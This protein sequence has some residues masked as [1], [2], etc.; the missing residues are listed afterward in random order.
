MKFRSR[1]KDIIRLASTIGHVCLI[2]EEWSEVPEHME[3]EAYSKG[4]ISEEMYET[5][6][7]TIDK[8]EGNV[9]DIPVGDGDTLDFSPATDEGV[10]NVTIKEAIDKMIDE[11]KPSD[12]TA[13][14]MPNLSVL[15]ERCGFPVP[16]V[17]MEP[18]WDFIQKERDAEEG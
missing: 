4:C 7:D 10:R 15:S 17:F 14:G 13:R 16:K 18:V 5:I 11:P 9:T 12:F 2:G 3:S 8:E 6:K 1:N